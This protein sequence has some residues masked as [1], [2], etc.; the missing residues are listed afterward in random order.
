MST[1]LVRLASLNL[2]VLL[3][4]AGCSKENTTGPD[5]N[6]LPAPT[7]ARFTGGTESTITVNWAPPSDSGS[8]TG[9]RVAWKGTA[10]GDT[11]ATTFP[12]NQRSAT[13]TGMTTSHAYSI[14]ITALH[15]TIVSAPATIQWRSSFLPSPA[16]SFTA[17]AAG[18][19]GGLL[20]WKA[21]ADTGIT[22]YMITWTGSKSTT[23]DT[24]NVSGTATSAQL[25]SLQ[26][27]QIYTIRIYTLRGKFVSR[28]NTVALNL[29]DN[30]SPP[31]PPTDL[32]ATPSSAT[33]V[34]LKWTASSDANVTAYRVR[35][36]GNVSG[37]TDSMDVNTTSATI[38]NLTAG[39]TYAFTVSSLRGARTSAGVPIQSAPSSRYTTDQ[40][41]GTQLRMYEIA[42]A[43]GAG[44]TIDP[45]LGGPKNI[46]VIS[47]ATASNVQLAIFATPGGS[48]FSIG[49]AF[50]FDEYKNGGLNNFYS[51][52]TVSRTTFVA[53]SLDTWYSNSSI[54]NELFRADSGNT[55]AYTLSNSVSGSNGQGFFVRT[56]TTGAYH[57]ARV[58]VKNV[59]GQLLQGTAGNRFVE[60]EISY[61]KTANIPYAKVAP[62]M[63]APRG[64]AAHKLSF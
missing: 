42:S 16:T 11:A 10:S 56:G 18:A 55:V 52:I 25:S 63:F 35:W 7:S 36:T 41:T 9:Y 4:L 45:S 60:L 62:S 28:P 19:T 39:Q 53:P 40:K 22:G 59:G 32:T 48:T 23:V 15:D 61:Q 29:D 46:S 38:T 51:D 57:Y 44:L 31:Q 43:N 49:P 2:L 30:L 33:S 34:I 5:T 24:M 6:L 3:L 1:S 50:A 64:V 27:G 47:A 54:E 17:T 8:V 12:A 13:L 58:F 14:Y 20:S 37:K 21:S 26:T